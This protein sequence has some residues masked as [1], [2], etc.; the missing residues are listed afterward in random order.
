MRVFRLLRNLPG[1]RRA[2]Y[3]GGPLFLERE[4][5]DYSLTVSRNTRGIMAAQRLRKQWAFV[6]GVDSG[7]RSTTGRP[8]F[9]LGGP[10]G[11]LFDLSVLCCRSRSSFPTSTPTLLPPSQTFLPWKSLAMQKSTVV[12]ATP[13]EGRHTL[14][15][16]LRW[17]AIK[18]PRG[19]KRMLVGFR[20]G[21]LQGP[22]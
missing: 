17:I 12:A 10:L 18:N 22:K 2:A 4:T 3:L 7:A 11:S 21:V 15:R 6:K 13:P 8:T 16:P 20:L 9:S 5:P 19:P 1:G 14:S